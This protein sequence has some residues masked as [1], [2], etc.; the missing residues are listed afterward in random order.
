MR[1]RTVASVRFSE[2]DVPRDAEVLLT[3]HAEEAAS[4]RA[5]HIPPSTFAADM[6][7]LMTTTAPANG[8]AKAAAPAKPAPALVWVSEQEKL[9]AAA[10]AGPCDDI[11][12]AV[13]MDRGDAASGQQRST[14][15]GSS[16]VTSDE[17]EEGEEAE[18]EDWVHL[19]RP[20]SD[21]KRAKM[22]GAVQDACILHAVLWYAVCW[23]FP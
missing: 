2:L 6:E 3:L 10:P 8:A 5:V 4:A 17:V 14:G 7:G 18:G 20:G 16:M 13:C 23:L 12:D 19:L 1:Q 21:R 22:Q 11:Q 9:H 15:G